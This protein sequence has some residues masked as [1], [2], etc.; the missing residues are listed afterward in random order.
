MKYFAIL[1][2][3]FIIVLNIPTMICI[4]DMI[5]WFLTD[6]SLSGIVYGTSARPVVA[7]VSSFLSFWLAL[8]TWGAL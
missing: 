2:G 3:L 6:N 4:V 5:W 1:A 8:F 7:A